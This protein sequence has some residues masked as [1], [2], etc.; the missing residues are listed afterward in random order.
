LITGDTGT[1]KEL[2]ARAIHRRSQ[3]SSHAFV[4]VNCAAI[5]RDLIASELFGHE[6][7][8][9]TGALQQRLGRF[10]LAEGGTLFLDEVGELPMETQITLLR[11]LQEREF[12][13]VGGSQSI[14]ADVR[15]IAA[16]NRDLES[17]ISS[18]AFRRDLY[19]RLNVF[20]IEIPTLAERK[21]DIPVLVEYFIDR[22]ARKAGKKIRVIEKNTL[23]LLQSYS[24]P[25]NIRELQNVIERSVIVCESETFSVDQSWL[26]LESPRARSANQPLAKLSTAQEK[27]K[28]EA[29]LAESA[30]RVS[31]PSGAAAIL[32]IPASTLESKI[33]SL[34]INKFRFKSR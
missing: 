22:Y 7:G 2:V 15:V 17:A 3:R 29:A 28:I 23:E 19:Y 8:S 9:F 25:G 20:P 24:W 18:G 33:R 5:P 21:E 11:V 4:S 30:G 14:R 12:E 31:G 34:K 13:R 6:K 10:E 1:G 16:T 32:G 27:Q 26:S